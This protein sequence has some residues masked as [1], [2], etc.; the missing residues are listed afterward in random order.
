MLNGIGDSLV[1]RREIRI[2]GR[3]EG[4]GLMKDLNDILCM[5]INVKVTVC[6]WWFAGYACVI[7]P[8]HVSKDLSTCQNFRVI[9]Q[10]R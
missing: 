9:N 2:Q 10:Y 3:G 5:R 6:A 1:N 7:L 4:D 8:F